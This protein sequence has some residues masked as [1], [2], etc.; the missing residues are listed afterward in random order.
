LTFANDK[1]RQGFVSWDSSTD[2]ETGR[3]R[4]GLGYAMTIDAAQ[5]VNLR[6]HIN[7]MPRGTAFVTGFTTYVAE[8][9]HVSQC[10]TFVA[11]A[12]LREAEQCS[13]PLGDKIAITINDLYDR[14]AA[15][16]GRKLRKAGYATQNAMDRANKAAR[17]TGMRKQ[18]YVPQLVQDR[19]SGIQR[20]FDE[21]RER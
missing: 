14:M 20:R 10:W 16:M 3:L 21:G 4:L 12:A 2:S 15:D 7:A 19:T 18:G 9:R 5:G 1:G 11:E 8:S 6:E 13:R 17:S